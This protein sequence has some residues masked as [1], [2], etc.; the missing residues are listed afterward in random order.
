MA[1]VNIGILA[2]VD[3]GKT[4][5]TE[6]ILVDGGVITVVSAVAAFDLNTHTVNLI[7][8]PRYG[9]VAAEAERSQPRRL[10][11]GTH[12]ANF[13][14]SIVVNTMNRLGARGETRRFPCILFGR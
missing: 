12:A 5:L 10:A 3:A 7:D 8:I 2:H 9:D 14:T 1:I 13:R 4:T 6:R 11:C